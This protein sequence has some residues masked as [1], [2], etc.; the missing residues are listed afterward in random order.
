[1]AEVCGKDLKDIDTNCVEAYTPFICLKREKPVQIS[2]PVPNTTL[3]F[4]ALTS[5]NPSTGMFNG[6]DLRPGSTSVLS[7]DR[8][9]VFEGGN[10]GGGMGIIIRIK[11]KAK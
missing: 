3:V 11:F 2:H 7:G 4:I 8:A 1:M 9:Q 5:L 6:V 10:R